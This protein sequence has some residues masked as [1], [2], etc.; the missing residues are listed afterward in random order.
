MND[1]LNVLW[2]SLKGKLSSMN[3]TLSSSILQDIKDIVELEQKAV[4]N[5]QLI[6]IRAWHL[7]KG[8]VIFDLHKKTLHKVKYCEYRRNC[9]FNI[10]KENKQILVDYG[11]DEPCD[12][13]LDSSTVFILVN[14][15]DIVSVH[16]RPE[17]EWE[18]EDE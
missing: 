7:I 8:D 13:F 3:E 16:N 6:E 9:Q 17:P 4:Q 5:L 11:N 2:L 14:I 15:A 10:D 1:A 18:D 12:Y